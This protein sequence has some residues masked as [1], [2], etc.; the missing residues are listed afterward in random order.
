MTQLQMQ[1]PLEIGLC[2]ADLDLSLGFWRDALGLDFISEIPTPAPAAVQS[3]IGDSAYR[4]VRLQLP[5]G[6]RIKLFAPDRR[7]APPPKGHL[8][9]ERP[10]LA[11]ITLIVRDLPATIANLRAGGISPRKPPYELRDGVLIALVD[12]P[13]GNIVELVQYRDIGSYRQ[14]R[15]LG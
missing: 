6:E 9:L 10:G 1:A 5:T 15:S 8:P 4:V 12:D 3:G 14:A 2:V 7:M 13:D 11:F